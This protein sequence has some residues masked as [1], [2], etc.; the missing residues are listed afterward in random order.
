MYKCPKQR[1]RVLYLAMLI[2]C[3]KYVCK[4]MCQ[5][6]LL[7]HSHPIPPIY[8]PKSQKPRPSTSLWQKPSF[9]IP[10]AIF[11]KRVPNNKGGSLEENQDFAKLRLRRQRRY[12]LAIRKNM[13]IYF[14]YFVRNDALPKVELEARS[15]SLYVEER[16]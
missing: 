6:R 8:I 13:Y 1:R 7:Q 4:S 5:N 3:Q 11:E 2:V 9:L 12:D 10:Q 16:C 14:I 15:Q